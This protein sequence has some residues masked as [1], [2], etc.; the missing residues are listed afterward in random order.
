MY[1][2]PHFGFDMIATVV[3]VSVTLFINAI[4]LQAALKASRIDFC[5]TNISTFTF[6]VL[7]GVSDHWREEQTQ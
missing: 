7:N 6:I 2:P 5:Q 3:C 1:F 4:V